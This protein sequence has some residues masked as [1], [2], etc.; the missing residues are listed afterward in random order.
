MQDKNTNNQFEADDQFLDQ[1]WADM[2]QLLDKELPIAAQKREQSRHK[3]YLTLLLFFLVSFGAGIGSV[4]FWQQNNLEEEVS[5]ITRSTIPIATNTMQ[6]NVTPDETF[7]AVASTEKIE[8]TVSQTKPISDKAVRKSTRRFNT[9]SFTN[10]QIQ[11]FEFLSNL[12]NQHSYTY[13]LVKFQEKSYSRFASNAALNSASNIDATLLTLNESI[14]PDLLKLENARLAQLIAEPQT[15]KF[16][17]KLVEPANAKLT[18]KWGWIAGLHSEPG[19]GYGGYTTGLVTDILVDSRFGIQ[20]GLLFSRCQFNDV[21][22]NDSPE[23][24]DFNQDGGSIPGVS[25]DVLG[26][27]YTRV[28]NANDNHQPLGSASYIS[29][30]ILLTYQPARKVRVNMGVEFGRLLG[31]SAY[32]L[33]ENKSGSSQTKYS[34]FNDNG[35]YGDLINKNNLSAVFGFSYLHNEQFGFDFR[36]NHGFSDLSKIEKQNDTRESVQ[37]SLLYSFGKKMLSK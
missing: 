24:L 20:T 4:L 2:N 5:E 12:T 10:S 18:V 8:T 13:N 28:R 25:N 16:T 37:F 29:T 9:T 33:N 11:P 15:D 34:V 30:P 27:P 31:A 22:L 1:A 6:Q 35:S 21:V 23:T 26:T 32:Q 17:P 3:Y 19:K 36:Y 7:N 14:R